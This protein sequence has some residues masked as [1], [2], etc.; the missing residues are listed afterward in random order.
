MTPRARPRQ[1]APG[2]LALAILVLALPACGRRGP[3][4]PPRPVAPAAPSPVRAEPED[5]A[6]LVTWARPTHNEDRT[7]LTDLK[8]FRLYRA[9]RLGQPRPVDPPPI[10]S[11]LATVRADRPDNAT[12]RGDLYAFRDDGAGQPL[13]AGAHYT[14][15]VQAVNR[16]G[17]AGPP[18][19]EV[20][21]DFSLPPPPP[22]HLS[23]V[24]RNGVIDLT[25]QEPAPAP[26]GS[27]T[28]RGYNVYR[29]T[30]PGHYAPEP[31]NGRPIRET[32][33]QDPDV[34][35]GVTYYYVV[36]S[37]GSEQPPW[38]ESQDSD[39]VAVTSI[40]VTPPA[41][42]Q[43]L[44]AVPAPS[45]IDLSWRANTEPDLLGY[46][47]YRREL[48]ALVP[49]RLTPTPIQATAFTDRTVRPG[50]TYAYW[51]TAVDRSPRHNESA[52]ST[53]VTAKPLP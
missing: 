25:W 18:S 4:V 27:S 34:G 40:D 1:L 33:Y 50:A 30:Q 9:V 3:P 5:G 41:P 7:P 29:G 13:T 53:E 14:Y 21:V 16:R 51:V 6:I 28:P 47:V 26:A 22:A 46:L 2:L 42:P 24:A 31:V 19:L 23:A 43:G 15:R 32:R 36:R 52:P 49:T 12:V 44:V 11:L 35:S 39:A 17:A 45:S 8:E 10:F 37:V 48:P 20:T 38:L